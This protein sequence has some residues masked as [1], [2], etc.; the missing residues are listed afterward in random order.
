[1][2]EYCTQNVSGSTLSYWPSPV[3]TYL[4]GRVITVIE[5]LFYCCG[6][7]DVAATILEDAFQSKVTEGVTVSAEAKSAG[8]D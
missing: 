8:T 7:A 3:V 5:D 4:S 1:M 6:P 2:P